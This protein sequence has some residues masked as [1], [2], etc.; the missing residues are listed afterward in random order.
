MYLVL[1]KFQLFWYNIVNY[2]NEQEDIMNET[3]IASQLFSIG[4][5]IIIVLAVVI[6]ISDLRR[7]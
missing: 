7:R 6:F 4:I 3:H 5:G 1:D 2:R